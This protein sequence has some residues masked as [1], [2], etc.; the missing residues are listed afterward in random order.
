MLV[1]A[2]LVPTSMNCG[3]CIK[4]LIFEAKNSSSPT[5]WLKPSFFFRSIS[6]PPAT[7]TEHADKTK[8]M[9]ESK[10][11][12]KKK[13]FTT[14][15]FFLLKIYIYRIS[16]DYSKKN[17]KTKKTSVLQKTREVLKLF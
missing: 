7:N 13:S 4:T 14:T 6:T 17:K 12:K 8:P 15:V 1:K 3:T 16:K 9:P 11:E 2:S 5:T 10:N